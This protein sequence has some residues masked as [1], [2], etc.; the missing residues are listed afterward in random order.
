MARYDTTPDAPFVT[1]FY[2]YQPDPSIPGLAALWNEYVTIPCEQ[3]L[4]H[5]YPVLKAH[6]RL[7]E[8]AQYQ[9][10]SSPVTRLQTS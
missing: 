8:M 3:A 10:W 2:Q 6:R 7:D 1:S 4:T 9:P 5:Y